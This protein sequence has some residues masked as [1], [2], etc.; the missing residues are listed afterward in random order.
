MVD[1]LMAVEPLHRRTVAAAESLRAQNDRARQQLMVELER[2]DLLLRLDDRMQAPEARPQAILVSLALSDVPQSCVDA[3]VVEAAAGVLDH[4]L[5]AVLA[6]ERT[7][8]TELARAL[9]LRGPERSGGQLGR[10]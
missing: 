7:L 5:R 8:G 2:R 9:E 6:Q 1:R 3:T 10:A 4:D